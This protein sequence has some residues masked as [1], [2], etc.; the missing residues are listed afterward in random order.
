MEFVVVVDV[1]ADAD[2]AI[3]IEDCSDSLD[4]SAVEIRVSSTVSVSVSISVLVEDVE[5]NR[6]RILTL[7]LGT[8][9]LAPEESDC[10]RIQPFTILASTSLNTSPREQESSLPYSAEK[11]CMH[12]TMASL[13]NSLLSS[14]EALGLG[15]PLLL[16]LTASVSRRISCLGANAAVVFTGI[17]CALCAMCRTLGMCCTLKGAD[18]DTMWLLAIAAAVG[19][20][21]CC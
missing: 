16:T 6:S 3:D 20:L 5:L 10:V 4:E 19:V 21:S 12:T 8:H 13:W 9:P 11:G 18:T 2:A 7:S 15:L 17:G 1:D 14:E